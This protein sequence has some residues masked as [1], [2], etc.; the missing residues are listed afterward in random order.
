M[1]D[2]ERK[3]WVMTRQQDVM[4]VFGISHATMRDWRRGTNPCPGKQG[5]WDLA[6]IFQWWK[7][8]FMTSENAEISGVA[9][10]Q[11]ERYRMYRAEQVKLDLEHR[12]GNLCERAKV[13]ELL[14][15]LA[16]MLRS[17]LEGLER[18]YGEEPA[19]AV[20]ETIEACEELIESSLVDDRE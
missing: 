3:P 8:R 13:H 19:G 7:A 12:Q 15:K 1:V 20:L 2:E 17:S 6:E 4:M 16:T 14:G 9:D 5:H 18:D 10:P 11:L